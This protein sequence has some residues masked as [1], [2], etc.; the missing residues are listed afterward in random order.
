MSYFYMA[1]A[2]AG[3]LPG[4][5]VRAYLPYGSPLKG[6][7]VPTSAIVWWQGKAWVYVQKDSDQFIRREMAAQTPV[8]EGFFVRKGLSA[9]DSI[10]VKGV[11]VLLSEEARAQ[12]GGAKAGGE[13]E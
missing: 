7:F 2:Q 10:V 9:K 4:M 8:K 12:A 3:F 5:N 1:P 11:Q 13:Q 6:L